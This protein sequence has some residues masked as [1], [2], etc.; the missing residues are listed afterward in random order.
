[1]SVSKPDYII[2]AYDKETQDRTPN[3]GAG[4]KQP[5]GRI[6]IK[7]SPCV[8]IEYDPDMMITLFPYKETKSLKVGAQQKHDDISDFF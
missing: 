1:M 6:Q 4:W 2:G 8:K 3:I 7:L 5:D